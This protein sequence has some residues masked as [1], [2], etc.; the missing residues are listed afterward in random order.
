MLLPG[1]GCIDTSIPRSDVR[2]VTENATAADIAALNDAPSD[3]DR[4]T[5]DGDKRIW[6]MEF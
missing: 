2:R 5:E 6:E 4:I 1:A 3:F